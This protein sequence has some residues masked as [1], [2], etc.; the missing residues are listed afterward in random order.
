MSG[1]AER[2]AVAAADAFFEACAEPDR[3]SSLPEYKRETFRLMAVRALA[4]A[5]QYRAARGA[6]IARILGRVV[7]DTF[8]ERP[9]C[10][11]WL[12]VRYDWTTGMRADE[13]RP[14]FLAVAEA[15]V[16]EGRAARREA[17]ASIEQVSA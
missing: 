4:T 14:I 10:P 7:A 17:G 15:I 12:R 9:D 3:W 1:L 2:L 8:F 5:R 13:A 16:G 11:K 6:P